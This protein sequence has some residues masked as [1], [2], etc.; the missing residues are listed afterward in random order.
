MRRVIMA[1]ELYCCLLPQCEALRICRS[2]FPIAT[3]PV[4]TYLPILLHP[5]LMICLKSGSYCL[6]RALLFLPQQV[7]LLWPHNQFLD[8]LELVRVHYL[9]SSFWAFFEF[10]ALVC[11]SFIVA[12]RQSFVFC[13]IFAKYHK[14][15]PFL[16]PGRSASVHSVGDQQDEYGYRLSTNARTCWY[17]TG[18][19][20]VLLQT[21]FKQTRAKWLFTVCF[22]PPFPQVPPTRRNATFQTSGAKPLVIFSPPSC[23]NVLDIVYNY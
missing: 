16:V 10:F 14:S 11:D 9:K 22:A 13:L 4:A 21:T 15:V 8:F 1:C 18:K 20:R 7:R 6:L 17:H 23:K 12:F 5:F 3:T 19:A 2:G